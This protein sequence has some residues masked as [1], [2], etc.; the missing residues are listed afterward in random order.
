MSLYKAVYLAC[1]FVE[2]L[3]VEIR[4]VDMPVWDE[5]LPIFKRLH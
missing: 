5:S 2:L 3:L 1:Q 4:D